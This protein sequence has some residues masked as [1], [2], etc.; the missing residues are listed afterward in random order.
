MELLER[1]FNICTPWGNTSKKL[2]NFVDSDFHWLSESDKISLFKEL[3]EEYMAMTLDY[4]AMSDEY[5]R[6]LTLKCKDCESEARL[7]LAKESFS[8]LCIETNN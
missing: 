7:Q 8:K 5:Y 6:I 4:K 1:S 3:K 2:K